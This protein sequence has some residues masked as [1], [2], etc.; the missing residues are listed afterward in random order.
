MGFEVE[1]LH[2]TTEVANSS[3]PPVPAIW[4]YLGYVFHGILSQLR[5]K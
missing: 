2:L 4:G 3:K 5:P 1:R